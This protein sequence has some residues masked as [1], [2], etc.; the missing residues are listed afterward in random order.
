MKTVK[1]PELQDCMTEQIENKLLNMHKEGLLFYKLIK[2]VTSWRNKYIIM[3]E[4]DHYWI[5]ELKGIQFETKDQAELYAF[6]DYCAKQGL[7]LYQ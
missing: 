5:Q 3:L 4:G 7:T 1:I 2:D 6:L